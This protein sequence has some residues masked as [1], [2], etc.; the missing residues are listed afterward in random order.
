MKKNLIVFI[1][2]DSCGWEMNRQSKSKRSTH[3]IEVVDIETG[4]VRWIKSGAKIAL[5]EGDITDPHS[6]EEYNTQSHEEETK[7][8]RK[9]VK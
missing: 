5:I 1:L 9:S 7:S 6:Q 4:Q 2:T 8:S 3:I